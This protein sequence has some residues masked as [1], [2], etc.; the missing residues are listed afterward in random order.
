MMTPEE[1][2]Q[3]A[4]DSTFRRMIELELDPVL[5]NFDAQHL[6]EMNRRIFQDLPELGY[7]EISPGEFRA[8]LPVGQEW[9]KNRALSSVEGTFCVAYSRMDSQ[10]LE[11]LD[12]A[13]DALNIEELSQLSTEQFSNSLAELYAELDYVHPFSDGNSRTLRSF[14]GQLAAAAGYEIDWGYFN[15][16]P[17]ARD[18]LYVARDLG[19]IER[20]LPFIENG[21]ALYEVIQSADRLKGNRDLSCLLNEAIRPLRAIAFETLSEVDAVRQ[22]PELVT[23]YQA[24]HDARDYFVREGKQDTEEMR[25][26]AVEAIAAQIQKQLNQ[27]KTENFDLDL[28]VNEIYQNLPP[29]QQVTQRR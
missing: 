7:V 23:A 6:K 18:L 25:Q 27:G 12:V 20:A 17:L 16:S 5:G 26:R 8:A 10:A 2:S 28:E 19:V 13:L 9:I 4:I 29:V 21:K 11:R 22:Y 15:R 14:T 3:R 1:R 24:L